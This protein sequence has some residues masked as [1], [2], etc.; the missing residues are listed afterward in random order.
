M[1][2]AVVT[3]TGNA[4]D[5]SSSNVNFTVVGTDA[6]GSTISEVI[7][8]NVNNGEVHG[9]TAFHTISTITTDAALQNAGVKIGTYQV[10]DRIEAKGMLS[11]ANEN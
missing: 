8:L 6:F 4:G 3:I 11:L 2:G 7:N 5:Y 10:G 9:S 1:H